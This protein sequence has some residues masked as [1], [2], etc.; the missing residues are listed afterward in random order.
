MAT[1][2]GHAALFEPTFDILDEDPYFISDMS[3]DPLFADYLANDLVI[4]QFDIRMTVDDEDALEA[5]TAASVRSPPA[6]EALL[7]VGL[8]G[9]RGLAA[10]ERTGAA[11]GMDAGAAAPFEHALRA[12]LGALGPDDAYWLEVALPCPFAGDL[13][14]LGAFF[15]VLPDVDV[16]MTRAMYDADVRTRAFPAVWSGLSGTARSPPTSTIS[17]KARR[18]PGILTIHEQGA[19]DVHVRFPEYESGHE[20]TLSAPGELAADLRDWL[21]SEGLIP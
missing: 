15:A 11:R 21:A 6:L 18:A 3:A 17:P 4:S 19:P 10:D 16:F 5:R 1:Q 13:G 14:S 7:G 2:F 8:G 12:K 20:I 9:V